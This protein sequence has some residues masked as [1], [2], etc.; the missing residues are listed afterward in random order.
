MIQV[1]VQPGQI[2]RHDIELPEYPDP[3][4]DGLILLAVSFGVLLILYLWTKK[5][6]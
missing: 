3:A 6:W 2:V 1:I 5:K 4:H